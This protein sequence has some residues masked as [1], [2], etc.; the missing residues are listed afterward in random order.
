[1][2]HHEL[3]STSEELKSLIRAGKIKFAGNKRLKIYGIL[4]CASGKRMK[5]SNRVFFST[6][7][8]AISAGF[9]ACRRCMPN[10]K[11]ATNNQ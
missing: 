4:R 5:K 9:H 11:P 8:E 10:P 6:E 3:L 7:Q 1:M 2:Y